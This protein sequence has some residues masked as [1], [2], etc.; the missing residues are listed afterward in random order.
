MIGLDF[1]TIF[2]TAVKSPWLLREAHALKN[3][4]GV[5]A[6]GKK[7]TKCDDTTAGHYN[8]SQMQAGCQAPKMQLRGHE[9]SCNFEDGS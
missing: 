5:F 7:V 6:S 8:W 4:M 1:I 3:P 2:T 9:G